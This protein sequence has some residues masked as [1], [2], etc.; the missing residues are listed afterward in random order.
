MLVPLLA[1]DCAMYASNAGGDIAVDACAPKWLTSGGIAMKTILRTILNTVLAVIAAIA[2]NAASNL[3]VFKMAEQTLAR[4]RTSL[5]AFTIPVAVLG[6]LLFMAGIVLRVY[7]SGKP[8][9]HAEVEDQYRATENMGT[10]YVARWSFY[11][12][13]GKTEG[14]QFG[15]ELP[16]RDFKLAWQSGAWRRDKIWRARFTVVGGA[17]M[18]VFGVFAA[19][20]VVSPILFS[21]VC[22]ALLIYSAVRL[23]WA[24]WY[25]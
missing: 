3:A 21:I 6:C 12:I 10:P 1:P 23:T 15:E 24:L 20:A 2:L 5:L 4:N 17:L 9:S 11:R 22:A 8:M 19:V 13:F 7:Q 14:R 16:F 25:A 18:A